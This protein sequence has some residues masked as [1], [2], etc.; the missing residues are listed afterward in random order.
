MGLILVSRR[1]GLPTIVLLLAGGF[2]L[3]P[4]GLGL[5]LPDSLGPFL[6]VI[7]SL[8]VA[9]IL[10]E[11]GLTLDL[12]GYFQGSRVIRRLL[13]VGVIITWL[14]GAAAVWL[15]FDTPPAFSLLVASLIIVTG[16]TVIVPILRRIKVV[17]R[18]HNILHWEGVL[19]DAIGV[20]IAILC[21]EWVV[22]GEEAMAVRN[23]AIRIVA[24]STIGFAGGLAI[25]LMI[26]RRIVPDG[27]INGFALAAAVFLFGMTEWI[28]AEAGLLAVTVAGLVIGWKHP[29]ELK[30]IRQFKGEITELLIGLLF[31]L[32]SARLE[33]SQFVDFGLPGLVLVLIVMF[34]IRPANV[35]V[36]T[37]GSDLSGREKA[38]LSWVAPRGI[39]AASMASLF[40]IALA[41][42][43]RDVSGDLL[44]TVTYSVIVGTVVFQGFT[45]EY[46]AR[47]LKVTR[48][49]SAD[50][51]I[52]GAHGLGRAMA[53]FIHK[54]TGLSAWLIDNN[55]RTAATARRENLEVIRGD[56]LNTDLADEIDELQSIGYVMA[57]TDNI[58][59]NEL[60][61]QR[62]S[63]IVPRDHLFRWA[64]SRPAESSK[65][66]HHGRVILN[67]VPR[68][69][70]VDAELARGDGIISA[71]EARATRADPPGIN[72]ALS[73]DS[74]LRTDLWTEDGF[75]MKPD[76]ICLHLVRTSGFLDRA[77]KTGG[78]IDLEPD[79][80]ADLHDQLVAQVVI[81]NP[82]IDAEALRGTLDERERAF[83]SAIGHGV[84]IPHTY[85][86]DLNDRLCL[87]A[88]LK[89]GLE[90][91]G[92]ELIHLVFLVL[93]PRGDA[94]GHLETIAEV[95][96][97]N[98][99][100]YNRL[101]VMEA[102][103]GEG[104]REFIH[105]VLQE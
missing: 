15:L 50:W 32:L 85:L 65:V 23:F 41:S 30:N 24:G 22:A 51:L 37:L 39:V 20:F 4:E 105:K 28:M 87:L 33:F 82:G 46:V 81:I 62:W 72:L 54:Q 48:P 91:E 58:E 55:P 18:L 76:D 78:V 14:G 6:P 3:G 63:D 11:G 102:Q 74:R 43:G 68:P 97:F 86:S 40:S 98:H 71:L 12:H 38:F 13:S 89:T 27:L 103:T 79:S 44:E 16:P 99:L 70:V 29:V 94:E 100:E 59:L 83:P 61:C 7:V 9:L 84:A 31:I 73:R 1:L 101:T 66:T 21:F 75:E 5:V 47:F 64:P 25:Y 80:L 52:C 10:F 60:I 8:S 42:G 49:P 53:R 69:S 17:P 36:S 88:R 56:A 90:L 57:L 77:L 45:A 35:L 93:S 95:A 67:D 104:A 96:R 2:A 19:I 26:K 92:G 34:V